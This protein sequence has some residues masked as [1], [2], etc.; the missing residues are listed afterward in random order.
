MGWCRAGGRGALAA[1]HHLL[2]GD[3]VKP[4]GHD[5][6]DPGPGQGIGEI[7]EHQIAKRHRDDDFKILQR[8]QGGRR[9]EFQGIGHADVGEGRPEPDPEQPQPENALRQH[10]VERGQPRAI[11]QHQHRQA[12]HDPGNRGVQLH[13]DGVD[14]GRYGAG[15]QHVGGKGERRAQRKQGDPAV[16]RQRWLDHQHCARKADHAGPD[17][18]R[19]DAVAKQEVAHDHHDERLE[20]HDRQRV[21]DRHYRHRGDKAVSRDDQ[22]Q[23]AQ[24]DEAQD[25]WAD[26]PA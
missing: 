19:P 4:R 8:R 21:G 9:R 13:G 16:K 20:K 18:A 24:A 12:Q 15:H 14:G 10:R 22:E 3:E 26:P 11:R 17:P 2:A 1:R 6:H 23:R 7:A 5:Q 25:H